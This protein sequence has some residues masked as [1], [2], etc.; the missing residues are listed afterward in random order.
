MKLEQ[1]VNA[2]KEQGLD[3]EAI[4]VELEKIKEEIEH[5]IYPEHKHDEEAQLED[6]PEADDE[7]M[8]RVF[9]I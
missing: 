1:L 6:K 2:L 5:F 7:K 8:A 3:D 4:K 9:G